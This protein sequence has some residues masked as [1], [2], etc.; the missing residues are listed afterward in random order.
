[1]VVRAAACAGIDG[2]SA[3]AMAAPETAA[4]AAPGAGAATGG[5]SSGPVGAGSVAGVVAGVVAVGSG[6]QMEGQKIPRNRASVGQPGAA[7][8]RANIAS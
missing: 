6:N 2:A 4:S 8:M 7:W 5:A 1:M 3:V